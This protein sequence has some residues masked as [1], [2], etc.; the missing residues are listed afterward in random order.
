MNRSIR[1]LHLEDDPHDAELIQRK[2]KVEGLSFE[3]VRVDRKET[4]ESALERG[5]FDLVLAD[6]SL[7]DYDGISALSRV[8]EKQPYLPVIVISGTL[9]EEEAVECLKAGAADYVLKNN[10][11]RLPAAVERALR[12]ARNIAERKRAEAWLRLQGAAL[13]AAANTIVITRLDG[14]IRWV[15]QAFSM[16]TGYSAEEA[17]GQNPRMLK[18]GRHGAEFYR[19]I[20]DTILGGS[21]WQGEIVNRCKD[22]RLATEEMTITPVRGGGGEITDFI[23][24][25]QDVTARKEA[26]EHRARLSAILESSPDFVATADPEGNVLYCNGAA[27]RLLE[28]PEDIDASQIKISETHPQWAAELVLTSGIPGAIRDGVWSG[29]TAF[30]TRSG[31]EIP[32]IQVILAHKGSDGRLKFLSTIARD[33]G[34]LKDKELRISRL[35]RVYAVLSGINT[36]IVH[37]RDRQ[38]LFEESCR[39]AVKEGQFPFAWIGLLD[40]ATQDVTPVAWAGEHAET[41]TRAKSSARDDIQGGK[42]R[43]GGRFGS[44]ARCSTT[45]L[46]PVPSTDRAGMKS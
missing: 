35:N 31:R 28:L 34:E 16:L 3:I 2:L 38:K 43:L 9:G 11:V 19:R 18:S 40:P 10:L 13:D 44:V 23:A 25:K 5:A 12:D 6:Y 26:E 27:R 4:F 41:L 8:R 29:E 7:P 42:E 39:I 22:G 21:V 37:V 15:N 46:R 45:T 33:I 17:I 36:L 30:I 20:Y 1:V 24:I 14:T 32:V